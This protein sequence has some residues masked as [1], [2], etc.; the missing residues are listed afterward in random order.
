MNKQ[1]TVWEFV[2]LVIALVVAIVIYFI[3]ADIAYAFLP[4]EE[5]LTAF[6]V[7]LLLGLLL[8]AFAAIL[9]AGV[10]PS[11]RYKTIAT[12]ILLMVLTIWSLIDLALSLEGLLS[13]VAA[14][15][16]LS[17]SMSGGLGAVLIWSGLKSRYMERHKARMAEVQPLEKMPRP[18]R[19]LLGLSFAS[20]PAT[21]VTVFV[22]TFLV[23]GYSALL[24]LMLFEL[25]R[26]PVV[27]LVAAFLA[28]V[29]AGWASLRSILAIF[30]PK[31]PF[32]P[33][34]DIELAA[35]PL[36][37]AAIDEVCTRV[38]T[39]RPDHVILHAEPTFFVTQQ[40]L[41]T[42]DGVVS[43]RTL[44]LG[45]PLLLHLTNVETKAI[46]AHEFA[47]FSGRD[48]LYST[49]V[50]QIYRSLG[51]S[52]GRL[53]SATANAG[54][55]LQ[56][57]TNL[58]L[59]PSLLFLIVFHEFFASIDAIVSRSR[60]LR[61]DWIAATNYGGAAFIAALKKVVQYGTHYAKEGGAIDLKSEATLFQQQLAGL[62]QN[63]AQ[64]ATYL[65]AAMEANER[66]FDSHPTLRTRIGS[67]P[68][69][70]SMP[71][72]ST[73]NPPQEG[74]FAAELAN[75]AKRLSDSL[76][77][78]LRQL[79]AYHQQEPATEQTVGD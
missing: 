16:R 33:A 12:T 55:W 75:E 29:I 28:P 69:A 17:A 61:A 50:A 73:I 57:A 54:S 18:S 77:N 60:E 32:Q 14:L 59:L 46:L 22:A 66:E 2:R 5:G 38:D 9:F 30:F 71:E 43:G 15:I 78:I 6:V 79:H 39:R 36:L 41:Q 63:E 76:T 64:L 24:L 7:Y 31:P 72:P 68:Q 19:L 45:M 47:H 40:K 48:T 1:I 65:D 52:I 26:I 62:A 13:V 8:P 53:R 74:E 20:I 23:V 35:T 70:P 27:L 10:V 34:T 37:H 3:L 11:W 25:P 58:L 51:E 49:W 4:A 21:Y 67:I 44:A 56:V 42:F